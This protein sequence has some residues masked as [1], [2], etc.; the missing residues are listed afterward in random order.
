MSSPP[1]SIGFVFEDDLVR[2][3]DLARSTRKNWVCNDLIE[4]PSDGRYREHHVIAT[5]AVGQ[6]VRVVKRLGDVRRLWAASGDEIIDAGVRLDAAGYLV[7]AV[8]PRTLRLTLA[9]SDMELGRAL[10]PFEAT[11]AVPLA[12]GIVGAREAF[13][14]FAL[15][16]DPPVDRR[17]RAARVKEVPPARVSPIMPDRA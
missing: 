1:D 7:A 13:W 17:R 11:V 3:T 9:R 5:V 14:R 10:Q 15:T 2:I 16:T 4:E 8:E 12:Q 6:L